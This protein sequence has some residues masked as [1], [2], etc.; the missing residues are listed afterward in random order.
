MTILASL[1]VN[2]QLYK[3]ELTEKNSFLIEKNALGL[4]LFNFH[5]LK[6]K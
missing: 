6:F 4:T 3:N 1:S 2:F 5:L